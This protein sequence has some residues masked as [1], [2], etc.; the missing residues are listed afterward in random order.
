M[1]PTEISYSLYSRLYLYIVYDSYYYLMVKKIITTTK[2][3][4]DR[5]TIPKPIREALN[6]KDGD[7]VVWRLLNSKYATVEKA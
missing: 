7:D 2:I 3:Y 5:T 1:V 4:D 6:L